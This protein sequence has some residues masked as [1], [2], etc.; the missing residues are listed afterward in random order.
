MLL[1]PSPPNTKAFK[2]VCSRWSCYKRV[3]SHLAQI[4]LHNALSSSAPRR[5]SL[6]SSVDGVALTLA[7]ASR[8]ASASAA[9]DLCNCTGIRTSLISTRATRIPHSSVASSSIVCFR[10]KG[11]D[12]DQKTG[13]V[14][15]P[16]DGETSQETSDTTAAGET[17]EL[18]NSQGSYK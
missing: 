5:A 11:K 9:M 2:A 4:E 14:I 6:P 13:D 12:I 16:G 8:V 17:S 1:H 10:V 3:E 7:L 18:S 15:S